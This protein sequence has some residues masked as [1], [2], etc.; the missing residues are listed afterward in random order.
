MADKNTKLNIVIAAE[1]KTASGFASLK[2]QLDITK[3]SVEGVSG[4]MKTVGTGGVAA[5]AGLTAFLTKSVQSYGEAQLA[6][7]KVDTTL[8]AMGK[9][10]EGAREKILAA[11]G[12]VVRL[13][14]DDE[15]AALSITKLYQ[16]TGDLNKAMELNALAMDL[17]RAKNIGLEEAARMVT[18]V[19]GGQGRALKEY[20][21]DLDET[22][23]PLEALAQLQGMVAGQAEAATSTM[24]VQMQV[25]KETFANLQDVIGS[26]FA[27]V[28]T[29]ALQTI[30]PYVEKLGE[31]IEKNPELAKQI[32]LITT[33]VTAVVAIMLPLGM[34]LPGI[35]MGFQGLAFAI[36][37]VTA[38]SAPVLLAVGAI[39]AILGVLWKEGYFTAEAWQQVWMGIKAYAVD[40]AN[41]VIGVV[42]DM[43]NWII[44]KVNT[45]IKAINAVL[46]AAKKIPGVGSKVKNISL[47]QDV[48]L[49]RVE[50]G[51]VNRTMSS[52]NRYQLPSSPIINITG[53]TLL[54][55]DV[56]EKIGDQL[57]SRLKLSNA[58]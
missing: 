2:K 42:E 15:A 20:G 35:I 26:K 8:K 6:L 36:G 22:K 52:T 38:V 16:V 5:L 14:F 50:G 4:A 3:V 29:S 11:S 27:P 33:A 55:D 24:V 49:D 58:I 45:A 31:W 18:L 44:K 39:V 53:N 48:A 47:I 43:V 23:T 7:T 9:T 12:A 37:L 40:G 56:A 28:I 51:T 41:S 17:A 30:T 19:L 1:N 34:A 13:G 10:A 32:F 57:I 54:S 21:I 46:D 25:L